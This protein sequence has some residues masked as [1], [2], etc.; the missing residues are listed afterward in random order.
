MKRGQIQPVCVSGESHTKKNRQE[1]NKDYFQSFSIAFYAMVA[2]E[3]LK[4]FRI[5]V[6][7]RSLVFF[8]W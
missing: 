8:V 7:E 3:H 6:T 5:L 1:N 4:F 2:T